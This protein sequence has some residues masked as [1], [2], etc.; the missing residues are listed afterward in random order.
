MADEQEPDQN[1]PSQGTTP[2]RPKV[3]P[4]Q[5]NEEWIGYVERGQKPSQEKRQR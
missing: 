3:P 5:P 4:Y 1:S 2:P